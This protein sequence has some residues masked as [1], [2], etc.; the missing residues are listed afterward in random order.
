MSFFEKIIEFARQHELWVVQDIAYADLV[1]DGYK[2]PSI[3]QVEGAKDHAVEFFSLSKSYNMPGWRVGFMSGSPVLVNAGGGLASP[4]LRDDPV[5]DPALVVA[6][7]RQ[8]LVDTDTESRIGPVELM[9]EPGRAL[10]ANAG[11]LLYTVGVRKR[12]PAGGEL[13][14]LATTRPSEHR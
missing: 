7:M 12:L 9:L 11:V 14:A 4:Y 5:L 10:V 13:I 1:F 2:A 6:S 3:L 8:A